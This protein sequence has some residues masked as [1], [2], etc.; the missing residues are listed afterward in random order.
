MERTDEVLSLLNSLKEE[1]EKEKKVLINNDGETLLEILQRKEELIEQL[2]TF[3][4]KD[5][6]LNKLS[7]LSRE[8]KTLQKTNLLLTEQSLAYTETLLNNIQ[9]NAQK[10]NA[11]SKKGT[12]EKNDQ[13]TFI[14]ESL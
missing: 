2:A 6:E 7:D 11:Y 4:D 10:K 1:L 13:P 8:I 9:K 14:D 5:V 12:I 3:D